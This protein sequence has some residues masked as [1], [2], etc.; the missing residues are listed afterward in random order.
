MANTPP[1]M[2]DKQP[3]FETS[4]A[5]TGPILFF[6][7]GIAVLIAISIGVVLGLLGLFQTQLTDSRPVARPLVDTEQLPVTGPRLQADPERDLRQL[8]AADEAA[9]TTY[10]W[11]DKEAGKVHIPIDQAM[12]MLL[13]QGLPVREGSE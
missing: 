11:V 9:L 2:P 8:Q 1:A 5:K 13:E 4:D 10:G 12:E 3:G 6:G 7:I